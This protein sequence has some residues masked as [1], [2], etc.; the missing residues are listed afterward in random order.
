MSKIFK[1]SQITGEYKLEDNYIE[2][3]KKKKEE[4]KE[5]FD[6]DIT[7]EE[8]SKERN[9]IIQNA[10][11]EAERLIMEA[12]EKAKLMLEEAKEEIEAARKEAFDQAY[13]EGYQEGYQK[14]QDEGFDKFK[15]LMTS[16]D[17]IIRDIKE[18]LI[19]DINN[20]QQEVI[21]LAFK[22]SSK[23][24][25]TEIKLNPELISNI[26]LDMLN[27]IADIEKVNIH[28]NP[29]YLE[30][31]EKGDFATDFVRQ[32]LEFIADKKLAPGDCVI[33]TDFGGK[34]G[35]IENKL[36]LLEKELL[37]GAGFDVE[38]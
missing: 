30:H 38:Y 17:N 29:L 37:K 2:Q 25:N 16:F 4:K 22:I 36:K 10:D 1:A 33:E 23:I 14:G 27:Q 15:T 6:I 9:R 5:Q 28:I 32:K 31:I 8:D 20:N 12:E 7:N 34:D 11:K 35:R 26:V 13:Q 21:K 19:D 24:I 3:E 18:K